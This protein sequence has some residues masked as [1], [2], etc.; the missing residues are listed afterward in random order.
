MVR[1]TFKKT[2]TGGEKLTYDEY[3]GY[4]VDP[5]TEGKSFRMIG[6]EPNQYER[7]K[8][9]TTST[10]VEVDEVDDEREFPTFRITTKSGSKYIIEF[11]E[12][13]DDDLL[14]H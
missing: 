3:E 10:L 4:A 9:L 13:I 5:P 7:D 14:D 6:V 1:C 11:Q 2:D 12:Q 8:Y